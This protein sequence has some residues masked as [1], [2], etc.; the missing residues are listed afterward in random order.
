MQFTRRNALTWLTEETRTSDL[1]G[2]NWERSPE[3]ARVARRWLCE[4]AVCP[5]AHRGRA[6]L[7]EHFRRGRSCPLVARVEI[8]AFFVEVLDIVAGPTGAL[9]V[10]LDPTLFEPFGLPPRPAS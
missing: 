4:P 3:P 6:P 2:N 1:Q 7:A 10:F 5:V 8:G 9:D